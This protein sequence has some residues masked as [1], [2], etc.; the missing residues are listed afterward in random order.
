MT[1]AGGEPS[2]NYVV[3]AIQR[4]LADDDDDRKHTE[5]Y[6]KAGD[7]LSGFQSSNHGSIDVIDLFVEVLSDYKAT[8][9]PT[10]IQS[11]PLKLKT[12]ITD[13]RI[14]S[15]VVP[16]G[17][18]DLWTKDLEGLE[19]MVDD[20]S[21]AKGVLSGIDAVLTGCSFAIAST[22]TLILTGRKNE[23]RRILTLLPDFHFCVVKSEDVLFD[24]EDVFSLLDPLAPITFISGPSATS[25]IELSRVEGV[26]GPRNLIVF[27]VDNRF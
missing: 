6:S 12:S 20:G 19:L 17:I 10:S 26:H 14:T 2:R 25:D 9:L 4:A 3:S 16:R 8:V 13:S 27:V 24:V 15:L 21:I 22:G 11:L 1:T 5:S 18:D 7:L 23:G